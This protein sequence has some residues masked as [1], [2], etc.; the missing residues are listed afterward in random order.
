MILSGTGPRSVKGVDSI[1][2]DI[3]NLESSF[4]AVSMATMI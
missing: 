1:D 3:A 2:D 4:R